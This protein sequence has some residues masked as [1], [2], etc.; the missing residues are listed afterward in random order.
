MLRNYLD[1]GG[2]MSCSDI[3]QAYQSVQD[4]FTTDLILCA[5]ELKANSG[6][7]GENSTCPLGFTAPFVD[8]EFGVDGSTFLRY[9]SSFFH[10]S[11]SDLFELFQE[12]KSFGYG[13]DNLL[14]VTYDT[15]SQNFRNFS[16]DEVVM[17]DLVRRNCVR[18]AFT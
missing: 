3:R 4:V 7:F 17:F 18:R 11:E 2:D 1:G 5:N 6:D 12:S 16:I 15:R 9:S 10:T 13:S 14:K 8:A